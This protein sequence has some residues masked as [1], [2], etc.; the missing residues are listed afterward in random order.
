MGTSRLTGFSALL[1]LLAA[2]AAFAQQPPVATPATATAQTLRQDIEQLKRDFDA[3]LAALESRLAAI[4]GGQ[5]APAPP[6]AQPTAEVPSGAGGAVDVSRISIANVLTGGM[7][8]SAVL[9]T[10]FGLIEIGNHTQN[11]NARSS[12]AI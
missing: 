11:G 7:K 3:R 8:L 1:A 4:D 2:S 10:E 6:P 5:A 9:K 12:T